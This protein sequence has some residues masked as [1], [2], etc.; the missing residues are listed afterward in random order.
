LDDLVVTTNAAVHFYGFDVVASAGVEGTIDPVRTNV[1]AGDNQ[2]F[3]IARTNL[4]YRIADVTTNGSSITFGAASFNNESVSTNWTWNNVRGTG[5]VD[6]TFTLRW[7]TL[8]G[9]NGVNGTVTP[10]STNAWAGSSQPFA[11]TANANYRILDVTTNGTTIGASAFDNDSQSTNWVWQG[12]RGTGLVHATFT[13]R[14]FLLTS[15]YGA[16]GTNFVVGAPAPSNS[17]NAIAGSSITFTIRTNTP[18]CQIESITTNGWS[19]GALGNGV[20]STNWVWSNV[21]STGVVDA[22]FTER[23]FLMVGSAGA[24]GTVNPTSTNI[25][26]HSNLTFTIAADSNY[27]IAGVTSNGVA[28]GGPYGPSTL[29]TNIVWNNVQSTGLVSATFTPKTFNLTASAG[30]QGMVTPTSTNV[31]AGTSPIFAIA[32][33]TTAYRILEVITSNSLAQVTNSSFDN[34]SRNYNFTWSDIQADGS[35]RV[36]FTNQIS[37]GSIYKMF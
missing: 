13:T 26:I 33:T 9:S 36:T 3:V 7:F 35:L 19:I 25:N 18:E 37:R 11:I 17:T 1:N 16:R 30:P 4:D 22:T 10:A 8:V 32:T 15:T 5:V 24:N 21:Q 14:K 28:I 2:L 27:R 31:N 6:A 12:V 34:S 20:F 29:T 23:K